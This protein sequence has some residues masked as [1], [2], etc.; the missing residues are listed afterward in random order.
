MPAAIDR[1]SFRFAKRRS[2]PGDVLRLDE[3]LDQLGGDMF[4][5]WG[6]Q[7]NFECL[8]L[9]WTD[10]KSKLL[11]FAAGKRDVSDAAQIQG[12]GLITNIYEKVWREFRKCVR[13][14]D[15]YA[16]NYRGER[17][18]SLRSD[19]FYLQYV[20]A[21]G[22]GEI[23]LDLEK[24]IVWVGRKSFEQWRKDRF[25]ATH[26]SERLLEIVEQV[27]CEYNGSNGHRLFARSC[28]G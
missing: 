14:V 4:P 1:K 27:V 23:T 13:R 6:T 19:I 17:R 7:P 20:S 28:V 10:K 24:H 9:M 12:L 3:A 16:I 8:P 2:R 26:V 25:P 22:T 18:R 15:V 11:S 5:D 21:F